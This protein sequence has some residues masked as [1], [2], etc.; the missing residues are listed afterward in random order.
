MQSCFVVRGGSHGLTETGAVAEQSWLLM[1]RLVSEHCLTTQMHSSAVEVSGQM[2][3][4]ML[5][6]DVSFISK[7]AAI[8][9]FQVRCSRRATKH[10]L[11]FDR[12]S[13]GVNKL[14]M[15]RALCWS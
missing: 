1:H 4:E 6:L 11:N 2:G 10:V 9:A 12:V 3:Q 8:C 14:Q 15:T 7:K 5:S 13:G